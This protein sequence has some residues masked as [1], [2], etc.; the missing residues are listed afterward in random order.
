MAPFAKNSAD[1][2]AKETGS[3]RTRSAPHDNAI[4]VRVYLSIMAGC[5]RWTKL[6]L[7]MMTL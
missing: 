5:P 3:S 1:D 7:I 2:D 4:F 6:P